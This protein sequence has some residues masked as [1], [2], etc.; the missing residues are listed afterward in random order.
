MDYDL[1]DIPEGYDRAR[2]HGP[3]Y[4]NLWMN[5]IESQLNEQKING[6]V[7]LGCGTGRFT[8]G[9][10]ARFN[11]TV[12]GVDPSDKML[13]RARAKRLDDRVQYMNGH[14]ESI[15]IP[16]RSVDMVFMSM[17]FHHFNNPDDSLRECGRVLRENGIAVLRSG[18][19]EQIPSYPYVPFYPSSYPLLEEILL[20][21]RDTQAI[22]ESNGFRMIA[23][24]VITQAIAPD[25]K[26]YA[27]KI[28]AGG[29]SVLARL[30]P[31]EFNEGLN[32]IRAYAADSKNAAVVEPIDLFLFCKDHFDKTP[33]P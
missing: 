29:D 13:E 16:S 24:K 21:S 31:D 6:I 9:L 8:E 23:S 1:T 18:T 26:S 20:S 33:S 32:A 17:S 12:F 3:E 19:L 14:S 30:N 11:T 10:A 7:D 22:F 4:I 5:E 15:P 28:A 2:D 27:E 25:W